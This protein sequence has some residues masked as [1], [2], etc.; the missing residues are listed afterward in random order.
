[1]SSA[2]LHNNYKD[3]VQGII[4]CEV[5]TLQFHYT[6]IIPWDIMHQSAKYRHWILNFSLFYKRKWSCS[7]RLITISVSARCLK[8]ANN[9]DSH[10]LCED[11]ATSLKSITSSTRSFSSFCCNIHFSTKGHLSIESTLIV[12]VTVA[13]N[14]WKVKEIFVTSKFAPS[15]ATTTFSDQSILKRFISEVLR[16]FFEHAVCYI[17]HSTVD[18]TF[19]DFLRR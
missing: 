17:A 19:S 18:S 11:R 16:Q 12:F 4:Y 15:Y 8:V 13:D 14:R 10:K 7:H 3:L 6:M 2:L 9:K 1:M 5:A